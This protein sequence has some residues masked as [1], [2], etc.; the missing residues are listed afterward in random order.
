MAEFITWAKV[1][2]PRHIGFVVDFS[3][4]IAQIMIAVASSPTFKTDLYSSSKTAK[5]CRHVL[6]TTLQILICATPTTLDHPRF[7][8]HGYRCGVGNVD[9]PPRPVYWEWGNRW[10]DCHHHCRQGCATY[11]WPSSYRVSVPFI[12]LTFSKAEL[13]WAYQLSNLICRIWW[14]RWTMQWNNGAI[15]IAMEAIFIAMRFKAAL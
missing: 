3:K 4:G 11:P 15:P 13:V 1:A 2:C 12:S 10:R 8:R 5:E 14:W 6:E 9:D 7:L